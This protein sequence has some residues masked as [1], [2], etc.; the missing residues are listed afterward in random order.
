MGMPVS[1]PQII[2]GRGCEVMD[3]DPRG[4]AGQLGIRELGEGDSEV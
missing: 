4:R 3:G 1:W 2:Q